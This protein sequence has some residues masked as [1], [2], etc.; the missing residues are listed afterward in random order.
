MSASG[1]TNLL[2]RRWASKKLLIDFVF[3]VASER[4]LRKK[5]KVKT[6]RVASQTERRQYGFYR[7]KVTK[8]LKNM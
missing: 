1:S 6:Q 4:M 8:P 5:K 3:V 7:I 2:Q